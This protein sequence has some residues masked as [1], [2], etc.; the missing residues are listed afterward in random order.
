MVASLAVLIP[1]FLL[2]FTVTAQ[3]APPAIG[4]DIQRLPECTELG[5]N[6]LRKN[7]RERVFTEVIV[8]KKENMKY[9]CSLEGYASLFL[10]SQSLYRV[11]TASVNIVH[12]EFE[13]AKADNYKVRDF[14]RKAVRSWGTSLTQM[15]HKNLFGCN[16]Q[17]KD[18]KYKVVCLY[19]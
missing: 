19:M 3:P 2:F 11:Y 6:A 7:I 10:S 13:D 12:T 18:N 15:G 14:I 9:D 17:L 16:Y 8:A 1:A 5:A 4:G